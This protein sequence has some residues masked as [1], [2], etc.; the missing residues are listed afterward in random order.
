[1]KISNKYINLI[2]AVIILAGCDEDIN[3]NR[4]CN[5]KTTFVDSTDIINYNDKDLI[6]FAQYGNKYPTGFY[7]E[8]L[9][10]NSLYYVNTVS[11]SES[12]NQWIYL[13]TDDSSQALNWIE[14]STHLTLANFTE[15]EKFFQAT[16]LDT[17]IYHYNILFRVHK[18][19]Y[20]DRSIYDAFIRNDSLG[21]FNKRPINETNVKEVIE[22]LWFTENYNIG[23]PKVLFTE[24]SE[25]PDYCVY[26]LYITNFYYGDWGLCPGLNVERQIY[27]VNKNT[28]LILYNSKII[29]VISDP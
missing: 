26:K 16:G 10:N 24:Y 14:L 22:Y 1:M 25:T 21:Y 3:K 20:L 13:C 15:T 11:V 5:L 19:S 12:Q 8:D 9:L 7:T 2:L 4:I 18:C 29:R 23:N 6:Y 17:S 27:S 28:G